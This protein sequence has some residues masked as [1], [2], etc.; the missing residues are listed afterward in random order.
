MQERVKT[1]FFNDLFMMISQ[2][3]TVRTATEIDARREEKLVQLGPVLER[4]QNEA[5]N[6]IMERVIAIMGRARDVN[7]MPIMPPA[8]A[9]FANRHVKFEYES[10]LSQ[11]Q[12]A[13][14]T[15]GIERLA[16]FVGNLAAAVPDVLDM[17]DWDD[18]VREYSD[19][20]GNSPTL[21]NPEDKVKKQRAFKAQQIQS[22]QQ[23]QASM[24]AVQ[25]AQTLSQTKLG[26][27]Q[28]ALDMMM[29]AK[30]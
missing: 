23:A 4:F 14:Q 25:G 17:P 13:S 10:M 21:L 30:Q 15:T 18:M 12:K 29:G 2:L 16:Q 3:D 7:G 27:G 5:L 19:L 8:P 20:L 1:T 9:S 24:A 26:G 11:A 6:P 28:S 22:Q